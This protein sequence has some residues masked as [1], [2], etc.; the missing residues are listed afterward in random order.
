M[1]TR[2]TFIFFT[3]SIVIISAQDRIPNKEELFG[4]W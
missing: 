4:E 2:I 3:L 1:R